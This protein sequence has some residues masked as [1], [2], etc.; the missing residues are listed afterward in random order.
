ML[1]VLKAGRVTLS[2]IRGRDEALGPLAPV[3]VR[4]AVV[5]LRRMF[6]SVSRLRGL[7]AQPLGAREPVH[8]REPQTLRNRLLVCTNSLRRVNWYK[9]TGTHEHTPVKQRNSHWADT[10]RSICYGSTYN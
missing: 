4:I 5:L 8:V 7:L 2:S 10:C 6:T 1:L 9:E 3:A